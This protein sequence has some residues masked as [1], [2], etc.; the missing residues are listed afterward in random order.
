MLTT[1]FDKM[2]ARVQEFCWQRESWWVQWLSTDSDS[3][4]GSAFSFVLRPLICGPESGKS[5]AAETSSGCG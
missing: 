1:I 5:P 2:T 4:D 3:F